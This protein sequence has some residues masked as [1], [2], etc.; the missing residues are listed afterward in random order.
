MLILF[1]MLR[2]PEITTIDDYASMLFSDLLY[3]I[4]QDVRNDVLN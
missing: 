1:K 4:W 2:D 3:K